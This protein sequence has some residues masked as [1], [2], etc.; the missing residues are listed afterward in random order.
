MDA[1]TKVPSAENPGLSQIFSFKPD[2]GQN[3]ALLAVPTA[4]NGFLL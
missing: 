2:A 4:W 1:E 3:V